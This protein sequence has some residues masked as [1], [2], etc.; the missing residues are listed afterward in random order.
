[1]IEITAPKI[2][3]LDLNEDVDDDVKTPLIDVSEYKIRIDPNCS[4]NQLF[5]YLLNQLPASTTVYEDE[6][7]KEDEPS[8]DIN[9][10]SLN[11][12]AMFLL[13][14]DDRGFIDPDSFLCTTNELGTMH[15]YFR[16]TVSAK[17]NP[18]RF[19]IM[20]FDKEGTWTGLEIG[21]NKGGL[22]AEKEWYMLQTL[23]GHM[24]STLYS[25]ESLH[26]LW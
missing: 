13:A 18:A 17:L 4:F 24:L 16:T 26:E 3:I 15:F 23:S 25:V 14:M 5:H 11:G 21:Y 10:S 19:L 6:E 2:E 1:M 22:V 8:L 20:G 9:L 7:D 12:F